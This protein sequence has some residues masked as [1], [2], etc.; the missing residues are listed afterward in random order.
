MNSALWGLTAICGFFIF[1]RALGSRIGL[2]LPRSRRSRD[3]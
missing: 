2:S 3:L 1:L